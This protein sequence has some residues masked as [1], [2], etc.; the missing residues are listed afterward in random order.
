MTAGPSLADGA[1]GIVLW[2]LETGRWN[3]AYAALQ[4]ATANGVSATDNASLYYGV[5]ALA[6]VLAGSDRP[7]LTR[8]Q[9]VA[10]AGTATVT[11]RRLHAAHRRIDQRQQAPYAEYDLIR[12]LTGLG[13]VVRRI[14]DFDLFREVLT[15][16]VRLTEPIGE[17]PG[18]WCPHGPN[19]AEPGPTGGHSNHGIAHGITGPLALL[20][21][22]LRDGITVDGHTEAINRICQWLDTWQRHTINAPWW[23]QTIT[24]DDLHSGDPSQRGPLRPS[25]CYGAPGIARAQQLTALAL[26]DT[27]RQRLAE[28]ALIACLNDPTQIR[29][30]TDRSLCHGTGGLL[31]TARRTAADALTPIPLA[32]LERLH[33]QAPETTDQPAGFLA[34]TSGAALATTGTTKTSWD[35]C[36]LLC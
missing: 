19:R 1:A 29:Q 7:A 10:A 3:A 17:L 9:A 22:T 5:P 31:T 26:G 13:V 23:P 12:G 2:H 14:G 25:W 34:G 33:E 20:A 11:R 16:L 27:T 30:L 36:L 18:W 28:S 24:L 21:L 32:P 35:A 6:F 8:A 15:Y 4:Q